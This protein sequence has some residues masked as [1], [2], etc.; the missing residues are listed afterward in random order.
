MSSTPRLLLV[1]DDNDLRLALE[2]A[3]RRAHYQVTAVASAE[4]ALQWLQHAQTDLVVSDFRLPGMDGM[5]LLQDL[6][7]RNAYLPVV[8][9]TAHADAMLA[10]QAL[11]AGARDLLLKPFRADQLL[12]VVNRLTPATQTP[13]ANPPDSGLLACDPLMQVVVSRAERG[14]RANASVLLSG[15]S[16]TGKEVMARHIHLCSP[17]AQQ[18]FVALNCAAITETL[19]ESTL[20][21]HEKGAF[22][23][24]VR[25]QAGTFERA[26]GGT[27]FLDEIGEMPVET[28]AKL[29]R[30]LQERTVER[31]GGQ[32]SI[33]VDI[34]LIAATNRNL[35]QAV[36]QGRFREDLY[37]RLA[38]FPIE[39]PALRDRPGDVVPLAHRFVQRYTA[40]FGLQPTS[41]S[42]AA[43]AALLS[44]S[45]PGNVRELENTIQRALL[46]VDQGQLEP[47]HLE[48]PLPPDSPTAA[49]HPLDLGAHPEPT[50]GAL[51]PAACHDPEEAA[52]RPASA[53][54]RPANVRDVEREHILS[55]LERVQGNR[56]EAIAILG[57][58]ER[59]LRYKLKAYR[60]Q[61]VWSGAEPTAPRHFSSA[62][63]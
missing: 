50:V 53:T 25:Q 16:G 51:P 23:G 26:N 14:A 38:V 41:L 13:H 39:L 7:E 52:P 58:S 11:K 27:L 46:L 1:E 19:L 33:P 6:R 17:R 36:T 40:S 62:P 28:Q 5:A 15:E 29:L 18:A 55:V 61:G 63:S 2:A 57:I 20:F 24:A 3:L 60:D 4:A 49:Q 12:E 59:A 56:R 8:L 31:V 10:I 37:Y 9:M 22:T 44:H 35:L 45:W 47:V 21:G 32:R 48:L 34:R 42:S 54:Q 30:V 43:E